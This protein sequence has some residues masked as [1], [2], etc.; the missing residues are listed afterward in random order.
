MGKKRKWKEAR[1]NIVDAVLEALFDMILFI[2][3]L[4]IKLFT[5][6]F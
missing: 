3:R 1:E 5:D 4:I 2:P 6:I